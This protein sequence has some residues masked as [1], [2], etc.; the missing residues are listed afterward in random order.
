M[1]KKFMKRNRLV[2]L[3]GLRLGN[4]KKVVIHNQWT[5]APEP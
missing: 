3:Y 1:F 4:T 2:K 5:F